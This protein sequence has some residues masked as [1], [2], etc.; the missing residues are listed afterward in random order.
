MI[1]DNKLRFSFRN[2]VEYGGCSLPYHGTSEEMKGTHCL[3]C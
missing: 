2:T 3:P 1:A